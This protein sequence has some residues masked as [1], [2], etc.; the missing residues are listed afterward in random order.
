MADGTAGLGPSQTKQD[1]RA[2]GV[3]RRGALGKHRRGLR[4]WR[5]LE[6]FDQLLLGRQCVKVTQPWRFLSPSPGRG[7][8]DGVSSPAAA[9]DSN[10]TT[11][12]RSR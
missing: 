5:A 12:S 9:T 10:V 4:T 6:A 1:P 7:A 2:G 11:R 8:A 3:S